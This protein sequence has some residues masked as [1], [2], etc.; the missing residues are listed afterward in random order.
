MKVGNLLKTQLKGMKIYNPKGKSLK[1]YPLWLD[2]EERKIDRN[3]IINYAETFKNEVIDKNYTE[4][5][6]KTFYDLLCKN[7]KNYFSKRIN[8]NFNNIDSYKNKKITLKFN[9]IKRNSNRINTD[10]SEF[11][12]NIII[13]KISNNKNKNFLQNKIAMSSE[14]SQKSNSHKSNLSSPKISSSYTL[15]NF[16]FLSIPEKIKLMSNNDQRLKEIIFSTNQDCKKFKINKKNKLLLKV[17]KA[18]NICSKNQKIIEDNYKR[19]NLSNDIN[20]YK[21]EKMLHYYLL[22]KHYKDSFRS[23]IQNKRLNDI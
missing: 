11:E 5:Y 4:N 14:L 21:L 10:L 8:L 2:P 22:Q 20:N 15:E 18:Q 17:K 1:I 6:L 23:K 3:I 16:K 7:E 13:P 9:N 19:R 12:D